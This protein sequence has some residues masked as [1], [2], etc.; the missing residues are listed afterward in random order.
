ML[1]RFYIGRAA[2]CS[3]Q[4]SLSPCCRNEKLSDFL[5]S[6]E[7]ESHSR[8]SA[9]LPKKAGKIL[10]L[11]P[12]ETTDKRYS[13]YLRDVNKKAKRKVLR[14]MM[15]FIE[16]DDGKSDQMKNTS[17]S[18]ILKLSIE[19]FK[20]NTAISKLRYSGTVSELSK[21]FTKA[22]MLS[23]IRSSEPLTKGISGSTKKKLAD[24]IV[25][26]VWNVEVSSQVLGIDDLLVTEAVSLSQ[27]EMFL[28]LLLNGVILK[29]IRG[30]VSKI[31]FDDTTRQLLLTG[32]PYQIE[33][34]KINLASDFERAHREE[35]DLGSVTKL[36]IEKYGRFALEQIGKNT[37]V[38]F[39]HLGDDRYELLALNQNQVKR[40]KRLLLWYLNYNLHLKELLVLPELLEG[41]N[42]LPFKDDD[43]MSWRDRTAELFVLQKNCTE[44]NQ[45]LEQDL[46]RFSDEALAK[47]DLDYEE[48]LEEART[49]PFSKR[50]EDVELEEESW[51]LLES[52]GLSKDLGEEWKRGEEKDDVEE[53]ED[54]PEEVLVLESINNPITLSEAQRLSL[55]QQLTDFKYRELLHGLPASRV[56]EPVFTI[57]LGNVLFEGELN[58][59]LPTPPPMEDIGKSFKFNSNLPLAH[60]QML[61]LPQIDGG[62]VAEDPH[63]YSLQ[64]KFMP[65]PF[66][67]EFR[68]QTVENT[69]DDQV[70]YP[71]VEIWMQLNS[72]SVPDLDTVQVVTVEAENNSYVCLPEA[73]SDL[74][75]SCQITG[76][77][78]ELEPQPT[79][80]VDLDDLSTLLN[81]TT[82]KYARFNNQ[83]GMVEFLNNSILDFSGKQ[84]TSI[85]PHI[86]L[87]T[88]GKIVRYNYIN[89]S[90]RREL[91]FGTEDKPVHLSIVEGGSLGG[92]RMEIRFVG[93]YSGCSRENFDTL[94]D[95]TLKFVEKL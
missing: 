80:D 24:H 32:T 78:L 14:P 30:A 93:D 40:T 34:A 4:F 63:V 55:Y 35:L 44:A 62:T 2:R 91:S 87:E 29:H 89:V 95:D 77:L 75:V 6:L 69:L 68:G 64:F 79:P 65:S 84:A 1:P 86:D 39:N 31:G 45:M 19:N 56:D 16:G 71:P 92:R 54:A 72:K 85:A 61:S 36:A 70:K 26:K 13:Q 74:K 49:L 59:V 7:T 33:N 41:L 67:E 12:E 50:Q 25:R 81:S 11:S 20:P 60:D 82:D 73:K 52:L 17:D 3:R 27:V 37:E 22:Q 94:L 83:P 8:Q 9:R 57:T 58:E 90:Y 10:I 21:S 42:L 76:Q 46:N 18:A 23:Y 43:S 53:P 88:N 47:S 38:Y 51:K 28:L 66:V 48:S 15:D 5:K